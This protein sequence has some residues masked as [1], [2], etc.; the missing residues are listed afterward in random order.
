MLREMGYQ[1]LRWRGRPAPVATPAQ[2]ESSAGA[3]RSATRSSKVP[4]G[5]A[6]DPFWQ[7]LLSAAGAEHVDPATLGWEERLEGPPFDFDGPT[8]R[9]NPIALRQQPASKRALWRTLRALRRRL[10]DSGRSRT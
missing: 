9:I 2:D 7:S 4:S 5:A 10:Q 1:P 8:L 6:A 3:A